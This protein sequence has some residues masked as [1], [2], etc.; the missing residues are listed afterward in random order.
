[1]S[2]LELPTSPTPVVA[3][4]TH[5]NSLPYLT[6]DV[7]GI[8]A[9]IKRHY[10]DFRVDEIPAYEPIGHGDHIYF[11]IEKRGLATMRAVND[12]ARALDIPPKNIGLAGLKDARSVSTQMFSIE[13]I[14]PNAIKA[15]NIPRIK[16]LAVSRHTNKLKIGHLRGNRFQIRLRE[17]D[18]NRLDDIR[19]ICDALVHRGVPNYFGRQR[20]GSR[21]DTW[22]IGRAVLQH[23]AKAA[24]DLILGLPGPFDTGEVLR[25]RQLYEAGDYDAAAKAWPYGFRDNVRMCR[26]LARTKGKH[27]RAYHAID[28]RLKKFYVNAFQS[29]LFNLVLAERVQ[30]IDRIETGD[31]AYKHE[32]GAVFR[33]EDA[34]AEAP[35]AAAF[36]ISA[37]GPI[38]G[39]KMTEP[40]GVPARIETAVLEAEKVRPDDFRGLARMKIHGARRPLRFKPDGLAIDTGADEHGPFIELRFTLPSGC[41]A[42]MI[43]SEVCKQHLSEGL[44]EE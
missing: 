43:L 40:T 32:N 17:I 20:F 36:E 19:V 24:V 13:H 12:I 21:G 9:A 42:T 5:S 29:Y 3:P 27:Q 23:D 14:D 18:A 37:T 11:T 2:Q 4:A 30:N 6:A 38:F 41:Y 10:E 35:R 39:Y 34:A 22:Q 44:E 7:P 33:V 26:E 15:L 31:L 8:A 28:L 1:M 16:V 25:A